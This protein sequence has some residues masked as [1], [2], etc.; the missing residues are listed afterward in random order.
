MPPAQ[1]RGPAERGDLRCRRRGDLDAIV[2]GAG[3]V[4]GALA[5]ALARDGFEVALVEAHEPRPWRA[6][7]EVDLRVVALA[8]DARE[9]LD[10]LDVWTSISSARAGAYRHMRVWDALAPGELHFDAAERGEAA[11]GWIV[12]NKL[13]QHALWRGCTSAIVPD[14]E[15]QEAAIPGRTF[16]KPRMHC[17]AEVVGIENRADTVTATLGDGTRLHARVLVAAEGAESPIRLRLGIACDGRDYAQ[18]AVVAHVA[19]GRPHES[20]AWQR[21]RPGGPLAF[22]P[23]ADGRC[24]I[25]WSLPD[26]EATRILA[27]DDAAFGNELGCAFDF[28]LGAITASTP[29]A[30]FPLRMRLAE[31]YVAGRCVL[32]GDAAHVVHPLA[33]QGMNL[34]LRDAACLRRVLRDAR[35]RGSDI[36][37]TH[38]LRRY[39]RE[40]RSENALAARGLDAIERIFGSA[41]LPI[42]AARGIALAAADRV[43]PLKQWMIDIASAR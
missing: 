26:A 5:L 6:E 42:A 25:V 9:L 13:V 2:V 16:H 36:G 34:G 43:Q 4:G 28:R 30:A 14:R 17:P 29:R 21:F 38:V 24:S 22:L 32:A 35:E 11:L 23:L 10:D 27:L 8:R 18:R 19:T 40:R 1:R 37:A 33:G 31:R 15:S 12:E 3:A 41:A 20:T 7:D 39:E